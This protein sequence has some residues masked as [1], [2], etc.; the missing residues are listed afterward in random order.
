MTLVAVV[1]ATKAFFVD[2]TKQKLYLTQDYKAKKL[3]ASLAY[4]QFVRGDKTK[5][6]NETNKW[7]TRCKIL[8]QKDERII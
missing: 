4:H 1:S 2:G 8:M 7:T 3:S 6:F 5:C